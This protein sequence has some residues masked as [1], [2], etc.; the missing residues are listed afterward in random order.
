VW[1]INQKITPTPSVILPL[2]ESESYVP[3]NIY[4]KFVVHT[5]KYSKILVISLH[6]I[7]FQ[8]IKRDWS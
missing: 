8:D 7:F 3:N 4:I 5:H 6:M 1:E 2:N